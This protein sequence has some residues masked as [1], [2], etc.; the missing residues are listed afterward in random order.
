M[1]LGHRPLPEPGGRRLK[2]CF[3]PCFHG[4]RSSAGSQSWRRR[5]CSVSI[6]V[7]MD[8]G[9]R[10]R[11]TPAPVSGRSQVSILVFMDL[12][13]RLDVGLFIVAVPGCFNPCFHGSRSSARLTLRSGGMTSS[14][15]NPCFH[16]SRSSAR[17]SE[18]QSTY[19]PVG[20]NP[21]FHGSRSSAPSR[22]RRYGLALGFQSLFSWI[23]VIGRSAI[24]VRR[25]SITRFNPC[26]HGSRSSAGNR[27][28]LDRARQD[29]FQSLFSWI[30]VIGSRRCSPR[31]ATMGFQSL[32]SWISVIGSWT[33]EAPERPDHHVS[34][35][36]FMDLGHRP[37]GGIRCTDKYSVSILVFMDLG[38]RH[39]SSLRRFAAG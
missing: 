4:S 10:P 2:R 32:F 6:L 18:T 21:C 31:E 29:M 37:D 17:E 36:V 39:R 9:H 27:R 12:G 22:S 26:F 35:L 19:S 30:S 11:E 5:S 14:S 25:T 33:C 38:H 34:I 23:S 7:F 8:L 16:G 20:F 24:A 3:N 15:F 28:Q 1:D 13:H